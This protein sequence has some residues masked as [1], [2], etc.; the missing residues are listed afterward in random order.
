MRLELSMGRFVFLCLILFASY[1]WTFE[2]GVTVG[3]SVI[4]RN[5]ESFMK[6]AALFLGYRPPP[7][8][9]VWR[10][11]ASRTW[12]SP[13]EM[14]Q[15]L[16]YY[17]ALIAKAPEKTGVETSAAPA[18]AEVE[19][20]SSE[21]IPETSQSEEKVYT[22]LAASFQNPENAQKLM[23]LLKSKGYPVTVERISVRDSVWHRVVVGTFKNREDALKF[24]SMF[25]SKE[26]LQGIV[27]QK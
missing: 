22:V 17:D 3:R 27:I 21:S 14:E 12:I 9:Q 23:M 5:E 19:E 13:E 24:L 2:L 4:V 1:L 26:G 10:A 25:N 20:E 15:E 8:E 16:G 18:E 6:K 11:D 7:V